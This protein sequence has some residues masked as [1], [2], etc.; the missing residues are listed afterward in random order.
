MTQHENHPIPLPYEPPDEDRSMGGLSPIGQALMGLGAYV[1]LLVAEIL[2]LV[3]TSSPA[4]ATLI[5]LA[6]GTSIS[7]WAHYRWHWYE[8]VPFMVVG[9]ILTLAA[10]PVIGLIAVF[11]L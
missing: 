8:F 11:L 9:L 10:L 7:I 3:Y 2:A 4:Q 5:V 6:A 1:V